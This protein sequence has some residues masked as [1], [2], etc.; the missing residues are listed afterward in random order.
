MFIQL[1]SI[2]KTHRPT[3]RVYKNQDIGLFVNMKCVERR[4]QG[5]QGYDCI[6]TTQVH[7]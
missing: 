6:N 4:I 3:P 2:V 7:Q 1:T 5:Y